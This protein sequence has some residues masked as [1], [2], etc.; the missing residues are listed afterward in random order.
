MVSGSGP[1][2]MD[3]SF[4]PI[5]TFRD[6][7]EGLGS[8]GIAS[9]R[10]E[11]RPYRHLPVQ[12]VKEEYLDDAAAAIAQASRVPGVA[13]VLLLGHSLGATLAPRIAEANPTVAGAILLA[14]STWPYPKVLVAQLEYQEKLG[15]LDEGGKALLTTTRAEAKRMEDPK[16]QPD[17][18]FSG[19]VTGA[20]FLDLRGYDAVATAGRLKI[21]MFFG[22]GERDLKVIP[23]DWAG[24]KTQ[25]GSRPNLTYRTYPG[26]QHL[27]TP[28]GTAEVNHVSAGVVADLAA[29]IGSGS[30]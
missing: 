6:L 15:F 26:L 8:R 4:G 18:R 25:L 10:F 1:T 3:E 29:W 17:A 9:L 11:K 21:P 23:D 19:G 7:A 22:W 12:T 24:W 27:F 20:Y 13:K 5:K 2:D 14:G 28:V 30:H 16:L